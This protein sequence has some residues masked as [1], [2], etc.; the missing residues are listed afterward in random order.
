MVYF[1]SSYRVAHREETGVECNKRFS[2]DQT[3]LLSSNRPTNNAKH[4][5]VIPSQFNNFLLE[6]PVRPSGNLIKSAESVFIVLYVKKCTKFQ[7]DSFNS[8]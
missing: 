6:L 7:D 4:K 1:T 8:F 5:R 2:T 3:L